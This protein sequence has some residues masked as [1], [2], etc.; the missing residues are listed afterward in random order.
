MP[1]TPSRL[2]VAACRKSAQLRWMPES[3]RQPAGL[4]RR[5]DRLQR[6]R[7]RP[8]AE[9]DPLPDLGG[10]VAEQRQRLAEAAGA[11]DEPAELVDHLAGA[12]DQRPDAGADQRAAQH[13][14]RR[15]EAAHRDGGGD[16]PRD[17]APGHDAGEG[18]GV[19]REPAE[20]VEE[21]ADRDPERPGGAGERRHGVRHRLERRRGGDRELVREPAPD[22]PEPGDRVVGA[23]DAVGVRLGDH[24][25]EVAHVLGRLAQRRGVDARHGDRAFLAEELAGDRGALGRGHE[26]GDRLR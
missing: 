13:H 12:D 26:V 17:P 19:A 10:D 7:Q 14:E 21:P 25:A 24:D 9:L 5:P 23:L 16:Q 22:Q 20:V 4:D 11:G 2:R 1:G 8:A 18:G 3:A 6:Q 15:G